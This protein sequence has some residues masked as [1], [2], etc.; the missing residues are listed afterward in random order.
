MVACLLLV[1][2]LAACGSSGVV[3]PYVAEVDAVRPEV[4]GLEVRA[5]A[6]G[7]GELEVTN[8]TGQE[9]T[10][11]DEEGKPYVRIAPE[12]VEELL[13]GTWTRT[14]DTPVYYCHDPRLVYRGP[15]PDP[16]VAQ[17]V[18]R[19]T[20]AGLAGQQAFTIEGRTLYTPGG[21][22]GLSLVSLAVGAILACLGMLLIGTILLIIIIKKRNK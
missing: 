1:V 6:G 10:L 15:E 17:V 18:K 7:G 20:I 16:P 22:G 19:W 13:G 12:G 8:R 5:T 2:P 4:P 21:M 11:L 9:V 14:R 3:L